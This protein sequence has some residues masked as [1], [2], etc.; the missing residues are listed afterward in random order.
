MLI[1]VAKELGASEDEMQALR[2]AALLH[3]IGK[4]AVP[5]Y[6]LSKPGHLTPEE[7]EKIKI[8]PAVGAEILRRVQFPYPVVPIVEA[9]HEK[10][11]GSGY[12]LGLEGEA[13][14][15]GARILSA[16]DCL[17]ALS[18]DREYRRA[19]PLGEA[20][21]YVVSQSGKSFDPRVVE[22]LKRRYPDLEDIARQRYASGAEAPGESTVQPTRG[23][24]RRLRRPRGAATRA[25]PRANGR[26][27]LPSPSPRP[28]RNSRCCTRLPASSAIRSAWKAPCLC[29]ARA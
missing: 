28:A 11:D 25:R 1:E 29:S 21:D 24:R 5:E 17:D 10:W 20:M 6:I 23:A 19:L 27:T 7:F 22:V 26:P 9:H 13:I 8:H 4:L 18:S 3:D 14:P 12:P 16:V 2:A 15:L